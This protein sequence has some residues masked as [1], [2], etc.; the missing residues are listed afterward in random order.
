MRSPINRVLLRKSSKSVG[1]SRCNCTARKPGR[2]ADIVRRLDV[3]RG[4]ASR[5]CAIAT[6]LVTVASH[7]CRNTKRP[8]HC[9]WMSTDKARLVPHRGKMARL[10]FTRLGFSFFQ[11]PCRKTNSFASL[12]REEKE[13]ENIVDRRGAY[14]STRSKK[15][16][17]EEC[18]LWCSSFL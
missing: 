9:A 1:A 8:G 14:L 13:E 17:K 6:Q 7:C 5:D 10:K 18:V 2:R 16:T 15:V 12:E 4:A 3:Y 11:R